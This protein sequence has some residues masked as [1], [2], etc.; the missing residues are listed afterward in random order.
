MDST[1][2]FGGNGWRVGSDPVNTII[3]DEVM[4]FSTEHDGHFVLSPFKA[5]NFPHC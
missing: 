1:V 3:L 4:S 2:S 5:R